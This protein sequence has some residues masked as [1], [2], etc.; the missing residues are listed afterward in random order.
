MNDELMYSVFFCFVLAFNMG[1]KTAF[2]TKTHHF[3]ETWSRKSLPETRKQETEK[4]KKKRDD[5]KGHSTPV[6]LV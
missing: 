2:V 4:E 6:T 1:K 5:K 3:T